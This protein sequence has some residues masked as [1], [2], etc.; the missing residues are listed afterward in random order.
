MSSRELCIMACVFCRDPQFQEWSSKQA[1]VK[2]LLIV[3]G[4]LPGRSEAV[5]KAVILT[6]CG[7]SSRNDLDSNAEAANIFHDQV[8]KPFLAWK[9]EQK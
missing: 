5:A 7:V 4:R 6:V 8:R 9:E 2:N 1:Q 3:G